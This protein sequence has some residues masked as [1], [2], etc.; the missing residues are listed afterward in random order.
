MK[1]KACSINKIVHVK[2]SSFDLFW[3]FSYIVFRKG[4]IYLEKKI[5]GSDGI[6]GVD[7]GNQPYSSELKKITLQQL[8]EQTDGFDSKLPEKCSKEYYNKQN[9]PY[10]MKTFI[11]CVLD[12]TIENPIDTPGSKWQIS[13]FGYVLLGRV[14]EK[15]SNMTY[16]KYVR[17]NVL[18]KCNSKNIYLGKN[19][20]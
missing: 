3:L 4:W 11:D 2:Y 6:L 7:Y 17:K 16:E 5:F 9:E 14:I 15:L 1:L 10:D 19:W 13:S 18:E 20:F 12:D 8:L